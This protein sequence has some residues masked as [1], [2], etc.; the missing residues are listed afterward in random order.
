MQNILFQDSELFAKTQMVINRIN[1]YLYDSTMYFFP[2]YTNHGI[3]HIKNILDIA[4]KLMPLKSMEYLTPKDISFFVVS[5]Y[6]HDI[7]MFL[8]PDGL[9]DILS[10]DIWKEKFK[11]FVK[12]LSRMS[13]I[14]LKKIYGDSSLFVYP[15]SLAD[16]LNL[17]ERDRLTYGEFLRRNH[18]DIAEYIA[19]N[20]FPGSTKINL[21]EE[22]DYEYRKI[23]G[24]LAKSHGMSVR[25]AAEESNSKLIGKKNAYKPSNVSIVYLMVLLRMGDILDMGKDR[26]PHILYGMQRFYSSISKEEWEWNQTIDSSNFNW[27]ISRTL[28]IQAEPHNTTQFVKV[29]KNLKWF[30]SE[31]DYSWAALC[32]YYGNKYNLTIHRI[33][34]N[35]FEQPE[36]F[37]NKFLTREAKI[38]I[39][40][41]LSK[42]LV[43]PLYHG[44]PRFAVRELIQ[45]SID[46][47][48]LRNKIE[49]KNSITSYKGKVRVIIDTHNMVFTIKD[50]GIGMNEDIIVN[51]YLTV[52]ANFRNSDYWERTLIEA[53]DDNKDNM[54]RVGRFG[55]GFLATFLL[56]SE[57]M[58]T[59]R[60]LNDEQGYRFSVRLDD[61]NISAERINGI[62]IGTEIKVNMDK[63]IKKFW[64]RDRYKIRGSYRYF[65]ENKISWNEW[66]H[67]INPKVHYVVDNRT[68]EQDLDYKVPFGFQNGINWKEIESDVFDKVCYGFFSVSKN[69]I[70]EQSFLGECNL[71]SNIIVNG[72]LI[73]EKIKF[74]NVWGVPGNVI[75]CSIS[76]EKNLLNLDLSRT[77]LHYEHKIFE[78][79]N[80]EIWKWQLAQILCC[81]V[82]LAKRKKGKRQQ[83][84]KYDRKG[85]IPDGI[86]YKKNAFSF[87]HPYFLHKLYLDKFYMLKTPL[88][89]SNRSIHIQNN[90]LD[91]GLPLLIY[92]NDSYKERFTKIYGKINSKYDHLF[93]LVNFKDINPECEDTFIELIDYVF[94]DVDD[95]WIPFDFNAR[96]NKFK[97]AFNVLS[98]Y[99][100]NEEMKLNTDNISKKNNAPSAF[101]GEEK[102]KEEFS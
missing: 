41:N 24:L 4:D 72:F 84:S 101:C 30:Q 26:S 44:D 19:I 62:E 95:L 93:E 80:I 69:N 11:R 73:D 50:N 14:E 55:V 5:V 31:L 88:N 38:R 39:T 81:D 51:Y 87:L 83:L 57:I 35:I 70:T 16:P 32:D 17:S 37:Q 68:V 59:T 91:S 67:C 25:S 66:Y 94:S 86:L 40:S 10:K 71:L 97:K 90:I 15:N 49:M 45:N 54:V 92:F 77:N 74:K 75:I 65:D 12:V 20:G 48:N 47:C 6:L 100:E 22:F 99:I 79:I 46:A 89:D 102:K 1:N 43:D 60:H 8:K 85:D 27:E 63:K 53:S 36:L 33:E 82:S 29:E 9:Y 13:D 7:G 18:A 52:G 56:G 98:G 28:Y 61:E 96:K 3:R 34:S 58:I 2:E 76:D 42:L 23:I 21:L 64:E 78:M